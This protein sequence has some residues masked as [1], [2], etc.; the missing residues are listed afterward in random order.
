[1]YRE[2]L[3]EL[4]PT[5]ITGNLGEEESRFKIELENGDV[6]DFVRNI[7]PA[8]GIVYINGNII[9]EVHSQRLF[10][11]K[12]PDIIKMAYLAFKSSNKYANAGVVSPT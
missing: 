1:M 4:N 2:G 8:Y 7:N 11:T 3:K 10:T 6:I 12:V 9:E 5:R